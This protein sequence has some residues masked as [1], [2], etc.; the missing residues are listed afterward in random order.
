MVGG[1]IY[2][3]EVKEFALILTFF[4]RYV[5]LVH[6]KRTLEEH[7]LFIEQ[8]FEAIKSIQYQI[9]NGKISE[10]QFV[11]FSNVSSNIE[12]NSGL[13][14]KRVVEILSNET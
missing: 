4:S 7:E 12:N 5:E 11:E 14:F 10:K 8:N 13:F 2:S 1:K 3:F 9:F 6:S